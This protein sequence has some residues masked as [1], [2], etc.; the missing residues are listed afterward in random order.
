V[1]RIIPRRMIMQ[2]REDRK[3]QKY[4][5]L[6]KAIE[7]EVLGKLIWEKKKRSSNNKAET[8]KIEGK[9]G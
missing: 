7:N 2:K 9:I 4:R 6:K 5:S 1:K 8:G 3:T